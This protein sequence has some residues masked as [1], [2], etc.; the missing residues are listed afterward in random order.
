MDR[1]YQQFGEFANVLQAIEGVKVN[2]PHAKG[3][4][5][6]LTHKNIKAIKRI[7]ETHNNPNN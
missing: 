2:L 3:S 6:I 5:D 4:L 7:N 1:P